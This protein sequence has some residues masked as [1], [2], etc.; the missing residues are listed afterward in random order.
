MTQHRGHIIILRPYLDLNKYEKLDFV[1]KNKP[2]LATLRQILS[3]IKPENYRGTGRE[4]FESGPFWID[5]NGI[6]QDWQDSNP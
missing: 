1:Q 2:H 5:N 3:F 6:L 4:H